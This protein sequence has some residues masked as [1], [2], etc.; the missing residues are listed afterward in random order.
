MPGDLDG[1]AVVALLRR[2][3]ASPLV[4]L[5]ETQQKELQG[6]LQRVEQTCF[7]ADRSAM[8]EADLRSVAS[9]WL[10]FAS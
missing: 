1:F 10:R 2:L 5:K 8:S 9:K 3:G 6:D 7:G 4:K